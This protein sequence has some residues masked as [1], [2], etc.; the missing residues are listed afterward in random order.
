VNTSHQPE[1]RTQDRQPVRWSIHA[2]GTDSH[3]IDTEVC[4]ISGHGLSIR[5][6]A[7]DALPAVGSRLNL[8][9]FPNGMGQSMS[10]S[11]T[12][13]ADGLPAVLFCR[14]RELITRGE[15]Q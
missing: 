6:N 10:G 9:V 15:K 13:A 2:T 8:T 3:L 7:D 14:D 5:T 11:R 1:Q 12:V 4:D